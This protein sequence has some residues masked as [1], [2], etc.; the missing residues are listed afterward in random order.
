MLGASV[1]PCV[2]AIA[3]LILFRCLR[4]LYRGSSC[5]LC[6]S[7]EI[8]GSL[9]G[10]CDGFSRRDNTTFA[11]GALACHS[12]ELLNLNVVDFDESGHVSVSSSLFASR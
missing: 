8:I 12:Q 2:V 5:F 11:T 4:Q 6:L 1:R 3:A 9:R 10:C 7:R